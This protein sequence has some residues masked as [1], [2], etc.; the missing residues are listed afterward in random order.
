MTLQSTAP[1]G[2]DPLEYQ[3]KGL[4]P[5]Q[6]A[7]SGSKTSSVVPLVNGLFLAFSFCGGDDGCAVRAGQPLGFLLDAWEITADCLGVSVFAEG[8]HLKQQRQLKDG[9]V[10]SQLQ[11]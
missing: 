9:N 5:A 3:N 10:F 1:C 6:Q 8:G 2:R 11:Q 4:V 7:Q